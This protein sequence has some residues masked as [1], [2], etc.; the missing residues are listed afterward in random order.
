M[1]NIALYW[2]CE[3]LSKLLNLRKSMGNGKFVASWPE[4]EWPWGPLICIWCLKWR[5]SWRYSSLRLCSLARLSVVG[6]RGVAHSWQS[7]ALWFKWVISK[8]TVQLRYY[9]SNILR[10]F[11]S[12]F[13]CKSFLLWTSWGFFGCCCL[14]GWFFFWLHPWH[15]EVPRP[16]NWT[17]PAVAAC[18]TTN[19]TL[20]P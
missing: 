5:L 6:G 19:T 10:M 14:V 15:V 16:G 12:S 11:F 1:V 18:T 9:D 13:L 17:C 7:I 3:S 8:F 20:D 4:V 2:V